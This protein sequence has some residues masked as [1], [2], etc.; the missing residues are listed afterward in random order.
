MTYW[1]TLF[2]TLSIE[3]IIVKGEE[4]HYVLSYETREYVPIYHSSH[5]LSFIDDNNLVRHSARFHTEEVD[6]IFKEFRE[7]NL[8]KKF[9]TFI[10]I[11]EEDLK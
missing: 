6:E 7:Y 10:E 2:E 5:E 3:E 8:Q 11:D 4:P 9:P 1:K